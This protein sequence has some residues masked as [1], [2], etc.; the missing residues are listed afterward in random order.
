[1]DRAILDTSF[2]VTLGHG[3][4]VALD[5]PPP[6]AAISAV[7]LCE[8]H[9]G[10]LTADDARRPKRLALLAWAEREFDVIPLDARVGPHYGRLVAASRRSG[11]G[12]P[13]VADA[14]IAATA[15]AH[16]LPLITCDRD[17]EQFDGVEV[18]VA[19]SDPLTGGFRP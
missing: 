11:R 17:F 18:V 8:L 3:E 9:H 6:E 1:M 2:V 14:L 12:R 15:A 5:D 16:K 4:N 13:G 19:R 10:L 7:T